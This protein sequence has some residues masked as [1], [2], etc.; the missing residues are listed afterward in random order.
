[1][2]IPKTLT[3]SRSGPLAAFFSIVLLF[4]GSASLVVAGDVNQIEAD[5]QE[6]ETAHERE[7]QRLHDML[8]EEYDVESRLFNTFNIT[9][10]SQ[11]FG[12][13]EFGAAAD[14]W[15]AEKYWPHYRDFSFAEREE[16]KREEFRPRVEP[17]VEQ[18]KELRRAIPE[19]DRRITQLAEQ[20]EQLTEQRDALQAK[21]EL[22]Q[23]KRWPSSQQELFTRLEA[24]VY[25][26]DW[27]TI[28]S[29]LI[30]PRYVR[31]QHDEL[32]EGNTDWFLSQ[33]FLP[34][35]EISR[36]NEEI[37]EACQ[38]FLEQSSHAERLAGIES[39]SVGGV[40][41][42]RVR[43]SIAVSSP[44]CTFE[45]DSLWLEEKDND[46]DMVYLLLGVWG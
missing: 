8:D 13:A 15:C 17:L 21:H 32:G 3:D 34:S 7:L 41:D 27:D 24:A 2:R 35:W 22:Q 26:H 14:G 29:D 20:I 42:R 12:S 11:G 4:A 19:Q 44:E 39:L 31:L 40:E 16:C 18:W 30:E 45:H 36:N 33:L 38:A 1:M 6:L 37:G 28:M 46:G 5:I 25:T 43:V 10:I 23:K 9:S